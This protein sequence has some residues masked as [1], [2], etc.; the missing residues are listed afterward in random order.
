MVELSVI[1]TVVVPVMFLILFIV[2]GGSF[3]FHI[4]PAISFHI[5]GTTGIHHDVYPRRSRQEAIDTDIHIGCRQPRE[6]GKS[7]RSGKSGPG[8][9][10]VE[11][12]CDGCQ[13]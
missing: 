11:G 9:G 8:L 13:Y 4:H 12:D 3:P 2:S 7:R 5:V 10:E 1:P 6:A